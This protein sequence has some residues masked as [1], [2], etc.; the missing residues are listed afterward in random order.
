MLTHVALAFDS[1]WATDDEEFETIGDVFEN[2]APHVD[3]IWIIDYRLHPA[4]IDYEEGDPDNECFEF[5][6]ELQT[7]IWW[8]RLHPL[9]MGRYGLKPEHCWSKKRLSS[10]C[11]FDFVQSALERYTELAAADDIANINPDDSDFHRE[12]QKGW[13]RRKL[14]L[15]EKFRVPPCMPDMP[16]YS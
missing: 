14:D 7:L 15:E 1:R 8:N 16:G 6:H 11:P 10:G 9:K 12:L 5:M 13:I 2:L 4:G 3:C